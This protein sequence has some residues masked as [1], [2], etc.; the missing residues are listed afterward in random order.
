MVTV[1]GTQTKLANAQVETGT[2]YPKC[3]APQTPSRKATPQPSMDGCRLA[4]HTNRRVNQ[5]PLSRPPTAACCGLVHI[6]TSCHPSYL[7][8]PTTYRDISK[9]TRRIGGRRA[10]PAPISYHGHHVLHHH[11]HQNAMPERPFTSLPAKHLPFPH[12]DTG[13]SD[14]I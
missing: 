14:A 1:R 2:G 10:L 13:S 12:P 6:D 5:A 11:H 3:V 8:L 9:E 4:L 7:R